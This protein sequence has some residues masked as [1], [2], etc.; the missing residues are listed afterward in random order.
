MT[1]IFLYKYAIA[2]QVLSELNF[3]GK[4]L[5]NSILWSLVIKHFGWGVT[6]I[7]NFVSRAWGAGAQS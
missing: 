2:N 4:T 5:S 7:S 1:M 6:A 3:F